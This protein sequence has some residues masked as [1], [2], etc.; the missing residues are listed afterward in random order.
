MPNETK[1]ETAYNK[2]NEYANAKRRHQDLE[3]VA[4]LWYKHLSKRRL[5][6]IRPVVIGRGVNIAIDMKAVN[7][8]WQNVGHLG[9]ACRPPDSVVHTRQPA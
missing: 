3:N 4:L 2:C 1:G 6:N 8:A 5:E 7:H 9:C